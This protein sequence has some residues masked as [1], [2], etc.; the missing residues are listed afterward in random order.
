MTKKKY[1]SASQR[2]MRLKQTILT[3]S[4]NP[5]VRPEELEEYNRQLEQAEKQAQ[6]ETFSFKSNPPQEAKKELEVARDLTVK[7]M[8]DTDSMGE[9]MDLSMDLEQI[10][11]L[12]GAIC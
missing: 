9:F 7:R 8:E 6:E 4:S 1:L 5:E 2:V 12:Q 11:T 3:L 10:E